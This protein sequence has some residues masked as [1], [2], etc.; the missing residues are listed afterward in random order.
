MTVG[1]VAAWSAIG[2]AVTL[3]ISAVA[4][5][6]FFGGAGEFWGPINDILISVTLLLLVPV[7]VALW[8][9]SP[10][11]IGPWF[12]ALCV[13]A[14]AGALLG[15][16]GQLLLVVGVVSLQASFVTGGVGI[17]PIV[18]WAVGLAVLVLTRDMLSTQVGWLLVGALVAAA[19]LTG[20]AMAGPVW[21]TSAVG[22]LLVAVLTAWLVLMSAELRAAF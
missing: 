4:L 15:A 12:G 22:V 1:E 3:V 11:D 6:L 16:M 5:A 20:A 21:L 13:A 14:L 2:A 10:D 8:R 19:L 17:I 9:L 7:I 18:A